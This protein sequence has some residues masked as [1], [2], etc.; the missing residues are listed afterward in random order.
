M[1]MTSRPR[2]F[3]IDSDR[4]SVRFDSSRKIRSHKDRGRSNRPANSKSAQ[5][6][7]GHKSRSKDEAHDRLLCFSSNEENHSQPAPAS[8]LGLI[9][10]TFR[11]RVNRW[12]P[13]PLEVNRLYCR[14]AFLKTAE[15]RHHIAINVVGIGRFQSTLRTLAALTAPNGHMINRRRPALLV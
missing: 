12:L 9:F 8:S 3:R 1:M 7:Q 15:A 10:P 14:R 13:K 5:R 6:N 11:K 2:S 4:G